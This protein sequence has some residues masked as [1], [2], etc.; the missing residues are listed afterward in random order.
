[1]TPPK[2]KGEQSDYVLPAGGVFPTEPPSGCL[3]QAL[4]NIRN[5]L[6]TANS[7]RGITCCIFRW[8][9]PL[10]ISTVNPSGFTV[11]Y[12]EWVDLEALYVQFINGDRAE[13]SGKFCDFPAI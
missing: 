1:M 6:S 7:G 13:H 8:I 9:H 12:T 2:A 10:K 11:V 5:V 3:R 4:D